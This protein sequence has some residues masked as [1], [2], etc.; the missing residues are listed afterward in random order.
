MKK[1]KSICKKEFS[2]FDFPPI[3]FNKVLIKKKCNYEIHVLRQPKKINI[4]KQRR[5]VKK[6]EPRYQFSY[7]PLVFSHI[8]PLIIILE[9]SYE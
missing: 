9:N 5:L 2:P 6:F 3:N 1:N 7:I 8:N 4:Y